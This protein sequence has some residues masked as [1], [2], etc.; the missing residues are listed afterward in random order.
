MLRID[1]LS[2]WEKSAYLKDLDFLIIGSGIVGL[3]TAIYLKKK[4]KNSRVLVIDRGYLPTGASTKNAGFTCFGSPTELFDDL[5]TIDEQVVWDTFSNR[6]HGLKLLFE[7]VSS[8]QIDYEKCKSWDIIANGTKNDISTDFLKYINE[9]AFQ[10]TGIKNIYFED[11]MLSSKFGFGDIKTSFCNKLE[12][13]IHTGKMIQQLYKQAIME[14]VMVL[15][16][17][18]ALE[19]ENSIG[20][21]IIQTQYGEISAKNTIIATNGFAKRWISDDIQPARAQVLITNEIP[22]LK[23]K[24]TFHLEKG[25]YY[26]RNVGNRI[27]L[28][29]GRNLDLKGETTEEFGLTDQIQ[30]KL[31]DLLKNVILPKQSYQI[32]GSWSGIMGVGKSKSPIIRKLNNNTAIGVRLGGMGVAIGSQVGKN[33][34]S[35]F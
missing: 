21:N 19:M 34:A 15:F 27:L 4:H 6:Y 1:N 31:N 8:T 2:Y 26:F 11:L 23:I 29:G 35:L 18:D 16:G 14:D 3:S 12:G 24:G 17:I 33:L 32:E 9:K 10:I 30:I 25:Y 28:G 7:L 20:G 5:K 22:N 13:A